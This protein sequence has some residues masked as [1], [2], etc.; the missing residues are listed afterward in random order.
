MSVS[1]SRSWLISEWVSVAWPDLAVFVCCPYLRCSCLPISQCSL[2]L[3]KP[4]PPLCPDLTNSLS[5]K[6]AKSKGEKRKIREMHSNAGEYLRMYVKVQLH[7]PQTVDCQQDN[8]DE[9]QGYDQCWG[10]HMSTL[11]GG[12]FWVEDTVNHISFFP[13]HIQTNSW[14]LKE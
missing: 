14:H 6:H 2:P 1:G 10:Q 7:L 13:Y 3:S 12:V 11:M 8:N 4:P 5:H 9:K